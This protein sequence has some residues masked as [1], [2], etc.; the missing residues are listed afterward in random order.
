MDANALA[1]IVAAVPFAAHL[2][3]R[4]VACSAARV[5]CEVDLK[6]EHCTSGGTAHGGFLMAFAD[7]AGAAGGF[8]A[9]PEGAK[10]TTTM[11]SKTNMMGKAPA[12]STLRAIS[13]PVHIGTR[14]SIWMTRVE[15]ADGRLISLTTQTQFVL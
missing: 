5:E 6:P 7:F 15:M 1:Q 4:V 3:I 8:M 10:G 11:E 13:T 2:G 9:L 14:T 12:G